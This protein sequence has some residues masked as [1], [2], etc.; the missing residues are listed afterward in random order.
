MKRKWTEDQ[1]NWSTST[2]LDLI[3]LHRRKTQYERVDTKTRRMNM[4]DV[5]VH[6]GQ[7]DCMTETA[8]HRIR[9]S[10]ESFPRSNLDLLASRVKVSPLVWRCGCL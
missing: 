6:S 5:V 10:I 7:C 4:H 8:M 9:L 1:N 2:E 3:P